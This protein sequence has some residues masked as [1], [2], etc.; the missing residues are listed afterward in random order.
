MCYLYSKEVLHEKTDIS[1][2]L[3]VPDCR[4]SIYLGL[5]WLCVLLVVVRGVKSSGKA[6]YFLAI[7]PYVVMLG[8]LVKS[9]TLDGSFNGVLYFVTPI[10]RRLLEPQV[11]YQAVSQCFF[12]LTTCFGAIVMFSS[13]NKFDHDVYR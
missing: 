5:S 12:S 4:L 13:H 10:W 9:M 8:L 2:G 7:F 6:A 1:D 3:G 11:W